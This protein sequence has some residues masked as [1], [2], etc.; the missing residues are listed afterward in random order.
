MGKATSIEW[1]DHSFNPWWGCQRVSLGCQNCYAETF[2]KRVGGAHWGPNADR[3]FFGDKYW[4]EPVRWNAAAERAGVRA[5]VFCA[6]MAD[7]F[8]DRRDLDP[9]RSRLWRLIEDTKWLDWL[10]LTK[11]PENHEMVPLAWQTGSRRPR[12]AW[13]G[14]SAEDRRRLTERLPHLRAATW[15]ATRFLSC[16]PLLGD[17]GEMD[18]TGIDWVIVGGE[19]GPGARPCRVEWIRSIVDQCRA[20]RVPAFAKQLGDD[21]RVRTADHDPEAFGATPIHGTD[22]VRVI[23]GPKGKD[24]TRWPP[25]LLVREFPRSMP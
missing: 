3:R 4:H 5:S 21:C 18:L 13:L 7:V 19:S 2:D 22:D 20:A 17:L 1:C 8:E 15:P 16:E 14:A 6:S 10:L 12:N 9:W 11:R 24:T 25:G 23:A